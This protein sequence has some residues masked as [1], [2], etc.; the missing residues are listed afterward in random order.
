MQLYYLI[1][2]FSFTTRSLKKIGLRKFE[3]NSK[4]KIL[5]N[6]LLSVF[7]QEEQRIWKCVIWRAFNPFRIVYMNTNHFIIIFV[8]V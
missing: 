6:I 8:F 4:L 7:A 1:L 5:T 3:V 2:E